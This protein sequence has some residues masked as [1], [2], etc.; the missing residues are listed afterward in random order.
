MLRNLSLALAG[1]L[2][3]SAGGSAPA[4]AADEYKTHPVYLTCTQELQINDNHC[5]CLAEWFRLNGSYQANQI[6][7]AVIRAFP[8]SKDQTIGDE[9]YRRVTGSAQ[10]IDEA[11]EL[12]VN[13][14]EY[15]KAWPS[16]GL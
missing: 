1:A 16:K 2:I 14:T 12:L 6:G 10:A 8:P 13:A 9:R 11:V 7:P 5:Y 3:L 15:C 4:L